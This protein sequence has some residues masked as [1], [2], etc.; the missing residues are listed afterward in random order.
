ME[1]TRKYSTEFLDHVI[2]LKYEYLE[3]PEIRIKKQRA[4]IN[5][6][7]PILMMDR[8][9]PLI[10]AVIS[11]I[12]FFIII[13]T[14]H[15]IISVLIFVIILINTIINNRINMNNYQCQKE[16]SRV[17]NNYYTHF[18]DFSDSGAAKE[19][20]IFNTKRFFTNILEKLAV[21]I[22]DLTIMELKYRNHMKT[23]H[24]ITNFI[25]KIS[26]Y[27]YLIYNVVVKELAIGS[28]TI[29]LSTIEQFNN[30]LNTIFNLYINVARY[31]MDAQDYIDFMNI[32][33]IQQQSGDLIPIFDSN[34][35]IEFKHVSFQYPNSNRY[36]LK[37]LNLKIYGSKKL[38]IVG[39]NGSG[40]TTFIK[41]LTRLYV[42]TEGEIL[43]NNINIK[44]YDIKKYHKLFAPVF[45]DYYLYN[46]SIAENIALTEQYDEIAL[47]EVLLKSGMH[48]LI[49]N[50]PTGCDT[51]I[52]KNLNANGIEPSGGEGQKIAIARAMYHDAPIYLLDEPTAALDPNSEY[53]IY[54]EFGDM[55]KNRTAILISHRL[56]GVQLVDIIAVFDKGHVVEYGTHTELYQNNGIYTEMFNNQ[57]QFY[58]DA[59]NTD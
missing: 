26:L 52:F 39:G 4:S 25:Q 23:I 42:P 9:T 44:N 29:Y 3:D 1:L 24:V 11:I 28:M 20:R 45:Q 32:P 15:P 6:N 17:Y 19:I 58:K 54:S 37:D 53:K 13:F 36:V 49:S 59:N 34:S 56:S 51:Q 12:I 43:L 8:L 14:L 18:N 40:K 46:L 55:I 2:E 48:S 7:A 21:K 33:E 10:N 50:L 5:V 27:T 16:I 31:S 22:D 35:I 47:N 38:C 57:A 41:L 30:A